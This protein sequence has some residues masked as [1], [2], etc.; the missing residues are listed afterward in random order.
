MESVLMINI[1]ELPCGI[2]SINVFVW[3][4]VLVIHKNP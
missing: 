3:A 4:I 1:E 2:L